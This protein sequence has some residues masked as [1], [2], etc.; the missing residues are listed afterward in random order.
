VTYVPFSNSVGQTVNFSVRDV[1]T[2]QQQCG[3]NRT[4]SVKFCEQNVHSGQQQCGVNCFCSV[5]FCKLD[6]RT[7]LTILGLAQARPNYYTHAYLY[8]VNLMYL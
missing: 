6:A 4:L 7:I 2:I 1:R 8:C 3:A 5:N